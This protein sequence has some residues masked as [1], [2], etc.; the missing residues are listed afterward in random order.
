V[1]FKGTKRKVPTVTTHPVV[2][3]GH[4]S[5]PLKKDRQLS[6]LLFKKLIPGKRHMVQSLRHSLQMLLMLMEM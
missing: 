2:W 1:C 4:R 5:S 6:K 3:W